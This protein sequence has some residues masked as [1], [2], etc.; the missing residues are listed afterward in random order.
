M[1]ENCVCGIGLSNLGTPEC[2]KSIGKPVKLILGDLKN[3]SN[4]YNKIA[5][6]DDLTDVFVSGKVE[7]LDLTER[8]YFSPEI[9]EFTST[10]EDT[11]Y[12]TYADGSKKALREGL[13][14]MAGI[15][16]EADPVFLEFLNKAKCGKRG[17]YILTD[18]NVL[19][20]YK[21]DE[22]GDV[23]L[24][25]IDVL[26]SKFNFASDDDVQNVSFTLDIPLNILD[27]ELSA[28]Y[29]ASADLVDT[30]GLV[31]LA[32]TLSTPVAL[33]YSLDL[34]GSGAFGYTSGYVGLVVGDLI[35][36]NVTTQTLAVVASVNTTAT[37][38]LYDL[39]FTGA[40]AT[41][42]IRVSESATLTATGFSFPS[43]ELA[44]A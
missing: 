32:G 19:V 37:E 2:E 23:Y 15:F 22:T 21:K 25:P 1:S 33:G 17:L 5:S 34:R 40:V 31:Q 6:T 29:G 36:Y 8:W 38:G 10:K 3:A 41:D 9:K 16:S 18:K 14:T 4:V 44:V 26:A 7:S 20:G 13:R 30:D 42:V 39:T 35:A 24:L 12:K 43:V 11:V 27:S 28:V